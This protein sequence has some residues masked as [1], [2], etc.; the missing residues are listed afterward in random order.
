M[1]I[2]IP[3]KKKTK[4]NNKRKQGKNGNMER[5]VTRERVRKT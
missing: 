1:S 2:E 3:H 4:K 5:E